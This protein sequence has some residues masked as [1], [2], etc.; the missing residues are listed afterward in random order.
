[1][2]RRWST[3]GGLGLAL[4]LSPLICNTTIFSL[5]IL[6]YN[7]YIANDLHNTYVCNLP[8]VFVAAA[9]VALPLVEVVAVLRVTEMAIMPVT[10]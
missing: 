7:I 9:L 1:M 10:P 5:K 3:T 2:V 4:I 6:Y 8:C